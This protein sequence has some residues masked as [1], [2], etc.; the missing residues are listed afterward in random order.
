MI[1]NMPGETAKQVAR[2]FPLQIFQV[3][4]DLPEIRFGIYWHE[5]TH[6]DPA[7]KWFRRKVVELTRTT[8]QR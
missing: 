4:L 3:P 2:R 5:R 6:E 1:A 8:R 7:H